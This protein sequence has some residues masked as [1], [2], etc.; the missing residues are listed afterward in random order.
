M[1]PELENEERA[2]GWILARSICSVRG[3]LVAVAG[4]GARR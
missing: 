4:G 3:V 2:G 1:T